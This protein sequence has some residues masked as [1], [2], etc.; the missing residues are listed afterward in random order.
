MRSRGMGCTASPR[1]ARTSVLSSTSAESEILL[2]WREER[3]AAGFSFLAG[4]GD[5]QADC[6]QRGAAARV[7]GSFANDQGLVLLR[8]SFQKIQRQK[9]LHLDQHPL[10]A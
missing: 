7:N 9:V 5:M 10:L 6:T 4:D 8:A 2:R 1:S 3:A